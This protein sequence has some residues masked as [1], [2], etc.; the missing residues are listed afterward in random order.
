LV[1]AAAPTL[2]AI[3]GIGTDIGATLLIVAGD[4]SERLPSGEHS[5]T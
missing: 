4:N 3:K 1:A 5:P 2:V